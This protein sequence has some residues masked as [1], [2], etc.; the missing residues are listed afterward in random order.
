MEPVGSKQI[1]R[2]KV[3]WGF[4][5]L[6]PHIKRTIDASR[7]IPT[8]E[9]DSLYSTIEKAYHQLEDAIRREFGDIPLTPSQEKEWRDGV[10][11]IRKSR[12]WEPIKERAIERRHSNPLLDEFLHSILKDD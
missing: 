3:V 8:G 12:G 1:G 5:Q 6:L 10:N 7:F 11:K 9:K 2:K 4:G